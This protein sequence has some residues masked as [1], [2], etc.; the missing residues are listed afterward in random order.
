M[1]LSDFT[2]KMEIQPKIYLKDYDIEEN[3]HFVKFVF[4]PYFKD[5]YTDLAEKSDNKTKG[6]N[7]LIFTEVTSWRDKVSVFQPAWYPDGAALED[8]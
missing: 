7:K 6:I 4:L 3:E 5:I 1:E 8:H 2:S